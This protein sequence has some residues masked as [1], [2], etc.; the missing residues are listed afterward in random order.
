MNYI[1]RRP[2]QNSAPPY[3][4]SHARTALKFGLRALKITKGKEILLPEFICDVILQPLQQLGIIPVYYRVAETLEPEWNDAES[5]VNSNTCAIIMVHYFGFPQDIEAFRDFADRHQIALIEDNAH[6]FGGRYGGKL[7]GTFGDIGI[8]SPRKSFSI[9]NGAFLYVKDGTTEP[10]INLPL[11]PKNIL[12]MQVR[13]MLKCIIKSSSSFRNGILNMPA[14]DDMNAFLE[15]MIHDW[16]M[17]YTSYQ[18]LMKQDMEKVVRLRQE[19]YAIWSE[20]TANQ[21]LKPV[22]PVNSNY[23]WAPLVFPAYT[24]SCNGRRKWF[25]WGFKNGIEV[26][27]WPSLPEAV[28]GEKSSAVRIWNKLVCFPIHAG[29]KPSCLRK[30]L[31]RVGMM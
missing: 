7:I 13:E 18:Y 21:G 9:L 1:S 29:M 26:H 15:P 22:L 4:F 27:S 3:L 17:D 6:S 25:E 11:E 2:T 16:G 8:S 28:Q 20:W 10:D 31:S 30:K 23:Q 12:F 19:I 14:Y 5:K 24:S